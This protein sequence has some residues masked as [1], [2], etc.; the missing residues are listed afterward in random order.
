MDPNL[1][2]QGEGISAV[3][4]GR[5]L[6]WGRGGMI[7]LGLML[8]INNG[9]FGIRGVRLDVGVGLVPTPPRATT[10]VVPTDGVNPLKS[11]RP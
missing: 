4:S 10:R 1:A 5:E 11:Q 6:Y 3:L 8:R 7:T 9:S 2:H